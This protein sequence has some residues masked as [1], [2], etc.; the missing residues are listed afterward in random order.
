MNMEFKNP[1]IF[2]M[3]GKAKHGKDTFSSYLKAV[4]EKKG[5]KV[6]ITQL[7]K[8]IK[9]YAREITGWNLTEED[10]PRELLQQLGT[11][12][13]RQKL[14]KDNLFIDRMIDDIEIFSYFYDVIII[15]DVRLEKEINDLRKAYP[16]LICVKIFRPNFDNGLTDEQKNHLTEIG[17]DNY[18]G[19]DVKIENTT[20]DKLRESTE[21]LY[22]DAE[23]Q[24]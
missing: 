8:Y 20:L 15:S 6:I 5:K 2:L 3:C 11:S 12:L 24:V 17:L 4:Y 19:F 1:K 14:N 9:Y 13:I 16:N 18:N 23:S 22:T 10:K 7:S 21:K